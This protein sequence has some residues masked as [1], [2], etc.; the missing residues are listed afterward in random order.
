MYR[1][2][3]VISLYIKKIHFCKGKETFDLWGIIWLLVTL[4]L[5]FLFRFFLS[6]YMYKSTRA[7]II[8][9]LLF[10]SVLLIVIYV[11]IILLLTS[12]T[13]L[14]V[15]FLYIIIIVGDI[16]KAFPYH[17]VFLFFRLSDRNTCFFF[18]HNHITWWSYCAIIF[19]L[20]NILVDVSL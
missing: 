20:D 19:V 9:H 12:T 7:V 1:H 16:F 5:L 2:Y 8:E 17:A 13:S 14:C 11:N 10:F 3:I 15:F 18:L 6:T 4:L